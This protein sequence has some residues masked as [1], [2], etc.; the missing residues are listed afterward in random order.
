MEH[1]TFQASGNLSQTLEIRLFQRYISLGANPFK[2]RFHGRLATIDNSSAVF[3]ENTGFGFCNFLQGIAQNFRMIQTD[4]GDH[5]SFGSFDHI[6]GIKSAAHPH[7][8]HHDVAVFPQEI[9]KSNTADQ[10][11]FRGTFLHG[12]GQRLHI[13]GDGSQILI[14]DLYPIH[15]HPLV[16]AVD[17]RGGI[18]AGTVAGFSQDGSGHGS[19]AALAVGSGNVDELQLLLRIA[20]FGK[21]R[22]GSAQA[23]DASLPANG[24]D[25][26]YGFIDIHSKDFLSLF[27][28]GHNPIRVNTF[29][30][31]SMAM[32]KTSATSMMEN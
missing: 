26:F 2:N 4:V 28:G 20:H 31:I 8:Q 29:T 17:I 11:K 9:F 5:R 7:F 25:I 10:L 16:E 22:L 24:V 30:F 27:T 18:Q 14:R 19:G 6:G 13:F 1:L 23:G 15:L 21:Q 3:F 32:I 12:L